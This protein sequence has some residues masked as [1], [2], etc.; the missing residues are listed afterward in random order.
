MP[1][2]AHQTE[3]VLIKRYARGRL[4]DVVNRRYVSLMS[5]EGKRVVQA[6][7]RL[8]PT[9]PCILCRLR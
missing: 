1:M 8:S 2:P 6:I 5:G 7:P 9:L 3:P 4:Y